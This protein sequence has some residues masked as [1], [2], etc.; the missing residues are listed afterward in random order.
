MMPRCSFA[1]R[2]RWVASALALLVSWAPA[3]LRAQGEIVGRVLADSG[4]AP[5]AA[6]QLSIARLSRSVSS[7]S[8]GRFR[9]VAMPRGEHLVTLR[10][11]GFR[12]ESA[13]VEINADEVVLHDFTLVRQAQALPRTTVTAR[14]QP[15]ATGKLAGFHE[16]EKMGI[17][18]FIGRAELARDEGVRRTGD[19]LSK[20]PGVVVQ[21]GGNRAWITS[22]RAVSG[23]GCAFCGSKGGPPARG[24]N[25]A[26]RAAGAR[27]ACFMDVYL[28]GVLVYQDANRQEG[29]FDVNS[30]DLTQIEAIEVYS[31]AAQIPVQFNRTS[32]GCGV[33]IIWTR[34]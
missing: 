14:E 12:P 11:F 23:T 19:V 15:F 29:L 13:L 22:G 28:D 17:G 20:V 6:A 31:S 2:G 21:R 7:D 30:I 5:V 34:I 24:L 1:A 26:D 33:M 25:P 16:R 18:H 27:S 32:G 9:F 10:A 8:T 4:R 3:R